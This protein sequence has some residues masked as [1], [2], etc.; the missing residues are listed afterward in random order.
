MKA[1]SR[2]CTLLLLCMSF[3][4]LTVSQ[5]RKPQSNGTAPMNG[6]DFV[7]IEVPLKNVNAYYC[8][9]D[10]VL[11]FTPEFMQEAKTNLFPL[12]S[13][14]EGWLEFE[15]QKHFVRL[16][17]PAENIEAVD[18]FWKKQESAK[19]DASEEDRKKGV[20]NICPQAP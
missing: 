15:R 2:F 10:D 19:P 3:A 17:I 5:G 4:V 20:T 6:D 13:G 8:R 14:N 1:L 18:Q 11:T 16:H 7:D 9:S 12:L